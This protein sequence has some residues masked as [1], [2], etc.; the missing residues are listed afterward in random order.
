[1]PVE[2]RPFPGEPGCIVAIARAAPVV[3]D[4][5]MLFVPLSRPDA[6]NSRP[7]PCANNRSRLFDAAN[8]PLVSLF[9]R[10]R[11]ALSR[12]R[13]VPATHYLQPLLQR[14]APS[15]TMSP[16]THAQRFLK[17]LYPPKPEASASSTAS[18][19]RLPPPLP[20]PLPARLA[21]ACRI[22]GVQERRR[23]SH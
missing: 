5:H 1:V 19:P 9:H 11:A 15:C 10:S 18:L 4:T 14:P 21:A 12:D 13:V 17:T 6:H 8:P 2:P 22:F 3:H 20:P 23:R 7:L 16:H